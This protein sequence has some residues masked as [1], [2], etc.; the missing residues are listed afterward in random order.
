MKQLFPK[1]ILEFTADVHRFRHRKRSLAIYGLLLLIICGILMA[2]PF[3]RVPVYIS[4]RGTI[5]GGFSPNIPLMAVCYM[6][7][8]DIALIQENSPVIFHLDAFDHN[9]WGIATGKV[10]DVSWDAELIDNHAVFRMRCSLNEAYLSLQNNRR[11]HLRKGQTLTALIKIT[12]RS[13]FDLLHDR[14]HDWLD[15]G[16]TE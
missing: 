14:W 11:A 12:E 13:L 15:P 7:P 16:K 2:L 4:S 5:Q 3:V 10:L 9:Q 6:Q 1:E 8:G